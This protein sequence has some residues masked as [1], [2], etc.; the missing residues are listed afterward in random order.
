MIKITEF[1]FNGE[2]NNKFYNEQVDAFKKRLKIANNENLIFNE[3]PNVDNVSINIYSENY[4]GK[5]VI[6]EVKYE[7]TIIG[8]F[9]VF[10]NLENNYFCIYCF[11]T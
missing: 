7:N 1:V 8:N 2:I 11:S 4:I 9:D 10:K 3:L 6:F 5:R